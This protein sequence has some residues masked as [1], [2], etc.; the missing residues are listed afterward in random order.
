MRCKKAERWLL[1]S[2]DGVLPAGRG[3]D[4][5]EHLRQCPSCR[6]LENE[7]RAMLGLLKSREGA[8]P[9]PYFWERLSPKLQE[10]KKA[11]VWVLWG[12]WCLRSVPVFL[13]LGFLFAAAAFLILPSGREEMTQSEALLMQNGISL[14]EPATAFLFQEAKLENRQMRLLFGTMGENGPSGRSIP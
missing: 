9:L 11:F 14:S 3:E 4:L 6:R 12:K 5:A 2:F 10:E 1:R 7:Y 8:E 13:L